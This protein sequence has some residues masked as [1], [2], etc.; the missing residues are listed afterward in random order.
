MKTKKQEVK[1]LGLTDE[2]RAWNDTCGLTGRHAVVKIVL[3]YACDEVSTAEYVEHFNSWH[4]LEQEYA[5]KLI[6]EISAV[7][8][9]ETLLGRRI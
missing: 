2:V 7:A 1:M 6:L 4:R 9:M 5:N 3:A 8:E